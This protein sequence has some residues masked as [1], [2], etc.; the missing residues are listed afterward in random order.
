MITSR[1]TENGWL[2]VTVQPDKATDQ[3]ESFQA[4][5]GKS[6]LQ[7]FISCVDEVLRRIEWVEMNLE[8]TE[9]KEIQL[10]ADVVRFGSFVCIS[11]LSI[12]R[13]HLIFR[14]SSMYLSIG[15][16]EGLLSSL[17]ELLDS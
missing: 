5:V 4:K 6:E 3:I 10:N 1:F 11:Y 14:S 15:E 17:K 2:Q 12:Y 16:L 8:S 7:D 9:S 13:V